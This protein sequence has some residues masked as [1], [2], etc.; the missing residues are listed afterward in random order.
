MTED[1]TYEALR[2]IPRRELENGRGDAICHTIANN[3][4][5]RRGDA[6][7]N[8][9][10][11]E[12]W[13]RWNRFAFLGF[14][15]PMVLINCFLPDDVIAPTANAAFAGTGWTYESYV[16]EINKDLDE[17]DRHTEQ[18]KRKRMW[19]MI[20]STIALFPFIWFMISLVPW[21]ILK[22][23]AGMA[24]GLV[25]GSGLSFFSDVFIS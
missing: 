3:I 10:E 23:F 24:L 5:L 4:R 18:I 1:D 17:D 9:A 15:H 11:L 8:K 2:R 16:A 14:N 21:P 25:L 20:I 22:P 12:S 19:F 6:K 13:K 7:A